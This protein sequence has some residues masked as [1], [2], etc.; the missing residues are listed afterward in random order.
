M[1][2]IVVSPT[3]KQFIDRCEY[4]D[5]FILGEQHFGLRLAANFTLTEIKEII[6]IVKKRKQKVYIAL[7]RIIHED[8]LSEVDEYLSE[9]RSLDIDGIIFGDLAVLR[10]ARKY[11]LVEKLIYNPETLITNYETV[12]FFSNYGIKRVCLAKEITLDDI[13]LIGSKHRLEIEVLGHG[14]MNMFHSYRDLLTNYYR[15]LKHANLEEVRNQELYLIEEHRTDKYPILEDEHGTHVFSGYDLCTVNYLD[16]FIENNIT[17]IR[18]DGLFKDDD[19]LLE[20]VKVYQKAIKDYYDAPSLYKSNK[21]HYLN[22]LKN[23]P[24]IRPFNDGFLFKKTIYK[25]DENSGSK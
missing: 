17:A 4:C 6:P 12:R 3:S 15:F 8:H 10:L 5:A 20:I 2:E 21:E 9:I 18:I 7:N 1:L 11:N 25:G 23:I 22:L 16:D 13:K 19:T 24:R 14:V